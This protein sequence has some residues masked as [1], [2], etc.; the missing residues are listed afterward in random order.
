MMLL[1]E[2][3]IGAIAQTPYA[4]RRLSA[5]EPLV[6]AA[7]ASRAD[8][9]TLDSLTPRSEAINNKALTRR[10]VTYFSFGTLRSTWGAG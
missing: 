6:T 3:E 5:L 4:R 9:R 1:F 8:F 2:V 7:M 10:A